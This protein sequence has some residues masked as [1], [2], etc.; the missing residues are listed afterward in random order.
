M[1]ARIRKR[2][3]QIF[4]MPPSLKEAFRISKATG[5]PLDRVLHEMWL[6]EIFAPPPPLKGPSSG[7]YGVWQVMK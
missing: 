2:I 4:E 5:M 7:G 6:A 1:I 3:A